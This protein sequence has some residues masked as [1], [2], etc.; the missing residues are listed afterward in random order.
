MAPSEQ[1]FIC[2][3]KQFARHFLDFLKEIVLALLC[4]AA[5]PIMGTSRLGQLGV[6]HST[7]FFWR[8]PQLAS[9][10][11]CEEKALLSHSTKEH[12]PHQDGLLTLINFIM[13]NMDRSCFCYLGMLNDLVY[14]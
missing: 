3:K 1:F 14:F 9:Q 4:T 10:L 2:T 7:D 6:S 5:G 11:E 12:W 13:S 8:L